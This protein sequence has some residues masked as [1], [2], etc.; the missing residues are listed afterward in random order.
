MPFRLLGEV[1]VGLL[2]AGLVTGFVVPAAMQL[3]YPTSPW[4]AVAITC[5]SIAA[6]IASG[7]RM[8]R[9]RKARESP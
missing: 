8:H 1:I 4:L 5:A 2:V 6:C 9:R 3:G 7:E